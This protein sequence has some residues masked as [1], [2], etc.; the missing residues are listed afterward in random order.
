MC[1][2]SVARMPKC[3]SSLTSYRSTRHLRRRWPRRRRPRMRRSRTACSQG[4]WAKCA[5]TTTRT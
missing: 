1:G 5:S 2:D 4:R 3:F